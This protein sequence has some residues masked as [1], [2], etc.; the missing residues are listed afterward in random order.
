MVSNVI[1]YILLIWAIEI[2]FESLIDFPLAPI[3][4]CCCVNFVWISHIGVGGYN[5]LVTPNLGIS[6]NKLSLIDFL[7]IVTIRKEVNETLLNSTGCSNSNVLKIYK[8]TS[9]YKC[10]YSFV[11]FINIICTT[12][13]FFADTIMLFKVFYFV[14]ISVKTQE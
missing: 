9:P 4:L 3:S 10:F 8:G 13:S 1:S 2:K 11:V 5:I 6:I 14:Y 12:L 7:T